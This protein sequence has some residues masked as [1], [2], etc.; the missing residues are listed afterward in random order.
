MMAQNRESAGLS[1]YR[2]LGDGF[3][4]AALA[5]VKHLPG[6]DGGL[7]LLLAVQLLLLLAAHLQLCQNGQP[8]TKP[9]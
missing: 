2:I 1:V 3:Y 6:A 9:C 7:L 8:Q 5:T 4:R